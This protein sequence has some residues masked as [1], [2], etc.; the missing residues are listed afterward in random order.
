MAA[1][2]QG[3][4]RPEFLVRGPRGLYAYTLSGRR[5]PMHLQSFTDAQGWN[6]TENYST[7][8]TAVARVTENNESRARTLI[9]GRGSKGLEIYKFAH[10]WRV[11]ADSN[12]PQYCTNFNTDS[13]PQCLAYKAISNRAIVRQTDIRTQYTEVSLHKG[14]WTNIQSNVKSMSNPNGPSNDPNWQSVQSEMVNEL[15][16]VATV[17]GWFDNNYLVLNDNYGRSADLLREAVGDVEFA[18]SKSVDV[19]WL[20][21]GLDI[22]SKLAA[23]I[24]DGGGAAISLG[25]YDS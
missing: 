17:R 21:M 15:G 5:L 23:F 19:K 20:E 4:A 16:Y 2:I 3:D 25:H 11:A 7:L 18:T 13:S 12:F 8:Q 6:L 22:V 24:P 9:F 1:D 14:D 10:G